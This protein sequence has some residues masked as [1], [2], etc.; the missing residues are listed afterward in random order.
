MKFYLKDCANIPS[1]TCTSS[2]YT[3]T[4]TQITKEFNCTR[5][6]A[7]IG[8]SLFIFGLGVGPMMLGPLSYV[9]LKLKSH[10]TDLV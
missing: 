9:M 7:T 10:F 5:L 8:L 3:S 1:S 6:V 2:I 4:Y